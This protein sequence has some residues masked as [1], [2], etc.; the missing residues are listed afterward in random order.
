MITEIW[1]S[2]PFSQRR[3]EIIGKFDT[4]YAWVSGD[5]FVDK[6]GGEFVKFRVLS[7]RV[8]LDDDGLSREVLALR[9]E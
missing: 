9:V 6:R 8:E 5:V 2:D 1:E 7:V 3:H 4:D